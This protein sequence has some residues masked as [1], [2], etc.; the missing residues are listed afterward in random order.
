MPDNKNQHYVPQ[1]YLKL[2]ADI[3]GNFNVFSLENEVIHEN[4]PYKD[5]CQKD[6][7][8]G[9]DLRFENKFRDMEAEWK[10]LFDKLL[11]EEEINGD[12]VKRIKQFAVYQ[13]ERTLAVSEHSNEAKKI[14]MVEF[15]KMQCESQNISASLQQIE[16][17]AEEKTKEEKPDISLPLQNAEECL[18]YTDDLNVLIVTYNTKE[19]LISSDAPVISVNK[20]LEPSVGY[21]MI[22]FVSFFPISNNKL[23]VIYDAKMYTRFR[24]NLYVN[25]TDENEVR[26]LNEYQL[27]NAGKI[28]YG[29]RN[30]FNE[31]FTPKV[32][33]LRDSNRKRPAVQSLGSRKEK[34]LAHQPRLSIYPCSLSFA[35]LNHDA[36][37]IPQNGRDHLTRNLDEKYIERMNFRETALMLGEKT[38]GRHTIKEQKELRRAIRKMNQYAYRYWRRPKPRQALR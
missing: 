2:F 29:C 9:S 26:L 27:I 31:C 21:A 19:T 12:D 11:N 6:Y 18:S 5:Q 3:Y 24:D 25:S 1:F 4:V 14:Q 23:V 38:V 8:Y 35:T 22:G 7:F 10:P 33:N 34:L 30:D 16:K 28:V 32:K 15:I 36:R 17:F 20:F 37:R 13:R